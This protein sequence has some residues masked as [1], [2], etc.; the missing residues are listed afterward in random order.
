MATKEN[1]RQR[2]IAQTVSHRY[3]LEVTKFLCTN[4]GGLRVVEESRFGGG[5]FPGLIGSKWSIV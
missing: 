1:N 5:I 4:F 2:Y 3:C